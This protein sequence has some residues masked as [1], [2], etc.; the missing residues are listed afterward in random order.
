MDKHIPMRTLIQL[1]NLSKNFGERVLFEDVNIPI[2]EG[3][4]IAL[5]GPNGCGKTTLLKMVE[6]VEEIDAGVVEIMSWTKLAI[7][8]QND[9]F[10]EGERICDYFARTATEESWKYGKVLKEFGFEHEDQERMVDSFSGG[11]QM[12]L[13]LISLILQDPN[14]ILLDEPTNYL[15]VNTLIY[16][17]HFIKNFKG[18]IITVSHDQEFLEKTCNQVLVFEGKRLAEDGSHHVIYGVE[19]FPGTIQEYLA[20]RLQNEESAIERNKQI[21]KKQAQLQVFVDKFRAK[22]SKASAAQSKMKQI[23]RLE[24]EKSGLGMKRKKVRMILP[25][26]EKVYGFL[27]TT[28]EL[29]IGYEAHAVAQAKDLMLEYGDK[30]AVVGENGQGKSTLLKTLTGE[31]PALNGSVGWKSGLKVLSYGQ[32]IYKVFEDNETIDEFITRMCGGVALS[33]KM[34]VLGSFLFTKYDLEKSIRVLSGGEKS[35]VYLASMFL[36]KADVYLLDE[37]TNHLD[38][39]TIDILAHALSEFSGTV[40]AISHNRAFLRVFA[41]KVWRVGE[42]RVVPY[43]QGYE[44]YLEQ[45]EKS[46][47]AAEIAEEETQEYYLP[48][49]L[50]TTGRVRYELEKELKKI[51]KKLENS[52]LSGEQKTVLENRWLEIEQELAE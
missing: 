1:K 36:Q 51:M 24:E 43:N 28:R 17:E 42:G 26:P 47:Q 21:E 38:F 40:V 13:R 48:K 31:I 16:L 14:V 44:Y 35:R 7:L 41:Q 39:E 9:P 22:A 49:N 25:N 5:V 52:N 18:T 33:D 27:L 3:R 50:K 6:G 37:P 23:E 30:V 8:K 11:W 29:N 32:N 34:R 45:I 10:H 20:N 12:R 4:K 19:E 15:D 2:V 46:A